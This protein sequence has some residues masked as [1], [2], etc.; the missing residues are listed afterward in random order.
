M[1][2]LKIDAKIEVFVENQ[3]Y[4]MINIFESYFPIDY[5]QDLLIPW[6]QC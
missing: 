5:F 2:F 1:F 3:H 4:P 6:T